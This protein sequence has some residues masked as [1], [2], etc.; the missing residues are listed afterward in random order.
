MVNITTLEIPAS[1]QLIRYTSVSGGKLESIIFE[2]NEDPDANL[3]IEDYW[4]SGN[5]Y[6]DSIV[7]PSQIVSLGGSNKGRAVTVGKK[8][9]FGPNCKLTELGRL[10]TFNTQLL[11][12]DMTNCTQLSALQADCFA[13]LEQ[14]QCVKLPASITSLGDRSF[15]NTPN[16]EEID[17]AEGTQITAI[18]NNTFTDCGIRSLSV[19]DHVVSI[20]REA[21]VRCHNLTAVNFPAST[22]S[23]DVEAFKFCENLTKFTVDPANTKYSSTDDM[24]AT[25]DKKTLLIFPPGKSSVAGTM[26]SPSFEKIGDYACYACTKL[27]S[28]IIPKKVTT[29][30]NHAFEFCDNLNSI[31]FLGDV[32]PA[33]L[34]AD[35][36]ADNA[37]SDP[38]MKD[39]RFGNASATA[40]EFLKKNVTINLRKNGNEGMYKA[41]GSYWNDTKDV[42]YSFSASNGKNEGGGKNTYDYLA[43]SATSVAVLGSQSTNQTALVPEKVIN[44]D[45]HKEYS[46]AIIGDYAFENMSPNVKEIVFLGPIEL[47]GANA[48][49]NGHHE[50][51]NPNPTS[52][53]E[54]IVF[55]NTDAVGKNELSTKRFELGTEFGT[56][57]YPEF[58]T[59]QKIYVAKS[60]LAEYKEN[61]PKFASQIDYR[62]PGIKV[63]TKYGTFSREFDVDL[64]DDGIN[65]DASAN[66]P[67]VA[68]FTGYVKTVAEEDMTY[69]VMRSINCTTESKESTGNGDGTYIP[70]NTGVLLRAYDGSTPADFYYRIGEQKSSFSAPAENVM[71]SVTETGT[72]IQP[73]DGD[74]SNYVI[75]GGKYY[76]LA[77]ATAIPVHKSYMHIKNASNTSNGKRVQMVFSDDSVVTGIEDTTVTEGKNII[78]N[79]QGQR[80]D[81]NVRGM[82]IKNGKKV[83]IK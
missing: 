32:P 11:E 62:I 59:T 46:V 15:F 4:Y 23:I 43:T 7:F 52:T 16:L 76:S 65:Y 19:P 6:I 28:I 66:R 56:E 3:T 21:F 64:D 2:N 14:Q 48:F 35:V 10:N 79:L 63:T 83:F 24:L 81:G 73:T 44:P 42:T 1:V 68:A 31:T 27:T 22:T 39:H 69:V 82:V 75:S 61:M 74:Y 45:N 12:I 71:I 78:Y 17:F 40:R 36:A 80:I 60:K 8:V 13:G 18:G 25:K 41:V 34:D 55:A 37:K 72:T 67:K 5:K 33:N 26:L 50:S 9:S 49:N 70:A 47:I 53:I 20:G 29:I 58:T 77:S 54:Q 30:G 38:N 57:E 51:Y